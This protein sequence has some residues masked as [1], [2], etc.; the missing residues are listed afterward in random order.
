MAPQQQTHVPM[1]AWLSPGLQ[2]RSG[3][4]QACLRAQADKPISH[5]HLFHSVLGLAGVQT[6]V[7]RAELDL[8]AACGGA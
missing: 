4:G 6:Q 5:D 8:F 1:V 3:V 7:K 2:Q